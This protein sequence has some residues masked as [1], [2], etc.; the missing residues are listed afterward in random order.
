M[1]RFVFLALLCAFCSTALN[2]NE[3]EVL[4]RPNAP[5]FLEKHAKLPDKAIRP[6]VMSFSQSEIDT[7]IHTP[8]KRGIR[9]PSLDIATN[10]EPN[11]L[12]FK[13]IEIFASGARVRLD[14]SGKIVDLPRDQREIYIATNST[15]GVGLIV[16]PHSG[17]VRGFANRNGQ[18][19][20]IKGNYLSQIEIT[21]VEEAGPNSC[22]MEGS[23]QP[24]DPVAMAETTP[25]KSASATASG[26]VISYEAVVAVDADS[27][28]MD[29]FGDDTDAASQWITDLFV[30]MNVFFERDIE[31][32]LLIGDVFLRTGSDPYSEPS[33]RN[34][35]LNEFGAYWKDHM[36]AVER[37]FAAMFSGRSISS[38]SFSGIAWL[39]QYCANGFSWGNSTPGSYSYNAIGSN[40]TPANTAIYVGHELG[41]NM[42]SPHTHCYSPPVDNCYNGEGGCYDGDP[43]CPAGGK[44]TVMSYCHVGGSSGAGCGTSNSEFH[45]TVQALIEDNLADELAAGCIMPFVAE[46]PQPVFSSEPVSGSTID[47][48]THFV[49]EQS[50]A[51]SLV[52]SNGGEATLTLDCS[53]SGSHTASFAI[54][55]CPASV[56]PGDSADVSVT[57]TPQ[58]VGSL[59]ASLLVGTNDP[60]EPQ[61]VFSLDCMGQQSL[62]NL[63]FEEGFEP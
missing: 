54:A 9:L 58:S 2:A 39:D 23:E 27:E 25:I 18:K 24:V 36:G 28:W 48:G 59:S 49:G 31:T 40:R 44:G 21:D 13:R 5:G 30:A 29:G 57:C 46:D 4:G 61:A 14:H 50:N 10:N 52:V 6:G 47:F 7:L 37:T 53:L 8:K 63:I 34:A 32:R 38:Y 62:P 35:Q 43:V 11:D 60:S 22:S 17:D 51:S 19:V 26:D 3:P 12:E 42:G 33:D 45:S 15:T 1:K 16:D 20:E 56:S 41:H 55:A